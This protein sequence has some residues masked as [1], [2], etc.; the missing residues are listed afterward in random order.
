MIKA[1]NKRAIKITPM[2][3]MTGG[4]PPRAKVIKA[5]ANMLLVKE[6]DVSF[7]EISN[8][9]MMNKFQ[10]K[11]GIIKKAKYIKDNM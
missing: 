4:Y 5:I 2:R 8:A 6:K 1:N 10:L 7:S 11:T 9:P 3:F